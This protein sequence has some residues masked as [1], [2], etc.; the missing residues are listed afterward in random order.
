MS[1]EMFAPFPIFAMQ[2]ELIPVFA[3][4]SFRFMFRSIKSFQSRL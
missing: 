4:S 2:A 3:R 1:V